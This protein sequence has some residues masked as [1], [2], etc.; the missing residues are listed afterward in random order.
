M[1]NEPWIKD[2]FD[3]KPARSLESIH[4]ALHPSKQQL[5][6]L[7]AYT[8]KIRQLETLESKRKQ[9][10]ATY[11]SNTAS[12]GLIYLQDLILIFSFSL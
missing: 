12:V 5:A 6:A 8:E 3:E 1:I 9:F 2:L 4:N 7:E 10:L 11:T